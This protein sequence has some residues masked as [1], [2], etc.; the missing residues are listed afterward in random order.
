[1]S[2]LPYLFVEE[3]DKVPHNIRDREGRARPAATTLLVR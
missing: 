1:M 2:K 3:D